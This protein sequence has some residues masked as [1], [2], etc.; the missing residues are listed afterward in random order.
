[1]NRENLITK[2]CFVCNKFIVENACDSIFTVFVKQEELLSIHIKLKILVK[3]FSHS[4][5]VILKLKSA[6]RKSYAPSQY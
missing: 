2:K 3:R 1:M 5:D 6:K 4:T